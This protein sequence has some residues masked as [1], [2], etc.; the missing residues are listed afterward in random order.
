MLYTAHTF[1]L[2]TAVLGG[3]Q[4][5]SNPWVFYPTFFH[6]QEKCTVLYQ[7]NLFFSDCFTPHFSLLMQQR[8][9][10]ENNISFT[11]FP[12]FSNTSSSR[13]MMCRAEYCNHSINTIKLLTNVWL[14][15]RNLQVLWR[16]KF[17]GLI[18]QFSFPWYKISL[19]TETGLRKV[20]TSFS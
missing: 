15:Q 1:I 16:Y 7:T 8:H 6:Q 18:L 14:R 17:T 5:I 12:S 11:Q 19:P 13:E 9:T 2:L 10:K 4:T 20:Y 3:E